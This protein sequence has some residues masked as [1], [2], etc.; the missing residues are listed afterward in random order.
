MLL[1]FK[2]EGTDITLQIE[3]EHD[4]AIARLLLNKIEKRLLQSR[5]DEDDA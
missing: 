2:E 5:K 1:F 4:L 3:D